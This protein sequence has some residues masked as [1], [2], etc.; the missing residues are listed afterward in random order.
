MYEAG[1]GQG[2]VQVLLGKQ[3]VG[4]LQK[5]SNSNRQC[6]PQAALRQIQ[7]CVLRTLC[8]KPI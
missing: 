6:M 1:C 7:L 4:D 3:A 8:L 5:L 2:F